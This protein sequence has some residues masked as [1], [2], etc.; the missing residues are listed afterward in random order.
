MIKKSGDLFTTDAFY[1]GHGV[2]CRGRMGAGIAKTFR[3]RF[4]INYESYAK[5]CL[6]MRLNP[7]D[8]FSVYENEKVILN[9]ATQL[10]PGADARY[11]AVFDSCYKAA[12]Q[13]ANHFN[14]WKG[15]EKRIAIPQIG[16]GIGGLEWDKV[17]TLIEA[18]EILVPEVTW[19][20]WKL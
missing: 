9:L 7:G 1:I 8:L 13:V 20:V 5:A 15:E 17:E 14:Y 11:E 6:G 12:R 18:V 10:E 2:N 19:E 16:C 3:E 4:P